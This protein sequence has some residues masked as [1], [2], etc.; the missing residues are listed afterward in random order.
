MTAQKYL[1]TA[2]RRLMIYNYFLPQSAKEPQ[3]SFFLHFFILCAILI[4][5]YQKGGFCMKD[6]LRLPLKLFGD[7][8]LFIVVT[9]VFSVT[10]SVFLN[11]I[12]PDINIGIYYSVITAIPYTMLIYYEVYD[13]ASHES[14]RNTASMK[15]AFL[16]LLIWQIPTILLLLSYIIGSLGAFDPSALGNIFGGIYFAPYIGPRGISESVGINILQFFIFAFLESAVFTV[17]YWL[18]M[19]DIV[20]IKKKK[21]N[22]SAST[23]K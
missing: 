21:K 14:G 5:Y 7:R 2:K 9:W 18:G 6:K 22:A 12:V 10:L 20:L 11:L 13:A 19:N 3:G 15:S 17:S 8:V 23:K 4:T 1:K 16:R